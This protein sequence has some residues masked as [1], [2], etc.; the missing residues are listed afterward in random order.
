[1]FTKDSGLIVPNLDPSPYPE[2]LPLEVTVDEVNT[3]LG[4]VDPFKATGPDG[5]PPKSLK[6]LAYVLTPSL[7][8]LFNAPL[9]QGCLPRNWK[10]ASVTPFFRKEIVVTPPTIDQSP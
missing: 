8:L 6:E 9:K 2:L 1:M 10:T 4:V 7:A 3:L 5:I